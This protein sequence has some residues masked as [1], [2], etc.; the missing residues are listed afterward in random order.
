MGRESSEL[1]QTRTSRLAIA[2]RI[3]GILSVIISLIY[4][5]LIEDLPEMIYL[6]ILIGSSP[7]I[8]GIVSL[9]VMGRNKGVLQGKGN[10]IAGICMGFASLALIALGVWLVVSNMHGCRWPHA[11]PAQSGA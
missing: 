8:F 2:S 11:N 1:A 9:I 10:A 4:V 6:V 5:V 7:L 3:L